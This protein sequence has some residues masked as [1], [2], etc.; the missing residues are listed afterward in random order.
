M[1][2]Q[3][4]ALIALKHYSILFASTLNFGLYIITMESLCSIVLKMRYNHRSKGF[5]KKNQSPVVIWF[6]GYQRGFNP[7]LTGPHLRL[8]KLEA[9][10]LQHL[11]KIS[12]LT[13]VIFIALSLDF[14]FL[15]IRR[16]VFLYWFCFRT[17][18]QMGTSVMIFFNSLKN[19]V[20]SGENMKCER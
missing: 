12:N 16:T 17:I 15:R 18:P 5:P 14:Q 20:N 11:I 4:S 2:E 13:L 9:G 3:N 7:F 1:K 19:Q 10:H 8:N 6:L